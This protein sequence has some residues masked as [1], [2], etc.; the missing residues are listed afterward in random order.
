MN[1]Y[2][3]LDL[4]PDAL[5]A[6]VVDDHLDIITADSVQ[7]PKHDDPSS[8]TSSS[9]NPSSTLSL[10]HI[11]TAL[12]ALFAKLS[13]RTNLAH[14]KSITGAVFPS[15]VFYTHNNNN[16]PTSNVDLVS[17][18]SGSLAVSSVPTPTDTTLAPFAQLLQDS[19]YGS[20]SRMAERCGTSS[21]AG[22]FSGLLA[23]HLLQLRLS[24]PDT[25]SNLSAASSLAA[26]LP[27]VLSGTTNPAVVTVADGLSYGLLDYSSLSAGT[28]DWDWDGI[29]FVAGVENNGGD[30]EEEQVRKVSSLLGRVAYS[31]P[32]TVISRY[33]VDKY[34]FD[35]GAL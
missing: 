1:Y 22:P 13:A 4:S 25:W 16:T 35:K 8:S 15:V 23:A 30:K 17:L 7:F 6:V 28:P 9:P 14:V 12:D 19:C 31:A 2:L 24:S 3:G 11:L 18:W 26:F 5:R 10:A 27:A 29:R 20:A 34:G 33:F 21:L 32:T